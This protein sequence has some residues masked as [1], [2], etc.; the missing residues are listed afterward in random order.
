MDRVV[1]AAFALAFNEEGVER[2]A[3]GAAPTAFRIWRAG[4]NRTDMGVHVF[5]PGSAQRLMSDQAVRGNRFS[6]DADHLSLSKT[7][8]PESRKAVGWHRLEVRQSPEGPELWAVDVE[9]TDAVRAGL[10]KDPPEW[11]YF[12]PAYKTDPDTREIVSYLNTA[13]TNNP[14]THHVTELATLQAASRTSMDYKEMAAAFFGDDDEKRAAAKDSYAKMSEAE[15]KAFKAAWRA[16]QEHAFEDAKAAEGDGDGDEGDKK[17]EKK[18][19]AAARATEDGEAKEA[20]QAAS[21]ADT[22]TDTVAALA[23]RLQTLEAAAAARAES[24]ERKT[25]LA[26]RP[27]LAPEVVA[28]L[29]GEPIAVVRKAI[30]KLPKGPSRTEKLA[31]HAASQTVVGVRG[32]TD[33]SSAGASP[34]DEDFIAKKM[35]G[36]TQGTGVVRAGR[37]LE[38]GFMTTAQARTFLANRAS[39]ETA[40][41]GKD[42]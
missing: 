10:E 30:A 12:S 25:L 23:A 17:P 4:P 19:E 35:G 11:R 18:P 40:G 16:A 29:D 41:A 9:W 42:S 6:I 7:A 24:D 28:W 8:P 3:P 33:E 37:H 34:S 31:A 5:S 15:R 38:L 20:R 39:A 27:D 32:R 13:I 21:A 2:P 22:E 36:T 14:A 26:T 1:V